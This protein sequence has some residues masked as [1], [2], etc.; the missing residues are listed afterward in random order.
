MG[1]RDVEFVSQGTLRNAA[2]VD[3]PLEAF[4]AGGDIHSV[5]NLTQREENCN[6]IIHVPLSRVESKGCGRLPLQQMSALKHF[7]DHVR[8]YMLKRGLTQVALA[9]EV[10]VS[11]SWLSQVLSG[12][13]GSRIET[14]EN[15]ALKMGK[16]GLG[17]LFSPVTTSVLDQNAEAG[18]L[19]TSTQSQGGAHGSE[20]V[21]LRAEILQI[22]NDIA[23][24]AKLLRTITDRL[25][26]LAQS[27]DTPA[28]AP[29]P[30]RV[31]STGTSRSKRR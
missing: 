20:A 16:S 7:Q 27:E 30:V 11:E 24:N 6:R 9:D 14:L 1:F 2:L 22:R 8:A 3:Q 19:S 15:V 28:P 26:T 4:G 23:G 21:A 18:V 10:G 29:A 13:R 25:T 31:P 12:K 17:E 5:Q